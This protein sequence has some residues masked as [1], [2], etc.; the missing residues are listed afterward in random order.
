MICRRCLQ[1]ASSL[2][3]RIP[4]RVVPTTTPSFFLRPFSSTISRR[5]SSP[6]P[7]PSSPSSASESP[8][9]STPLADTPAA[10][11]KPTL[12]ACPEGTV[13]TGLNYFKNRTDP[14]ALADDAYPAWLWNCLNVQKKVADEADDDAGDEF[15]KSKKQRKLA[16]KRQRA[17]EARLL[18]EGNLEALAPKIPLQHQTINLPGNEEGTT[19]GA[20]AAAAARE[21]LRKAMR[22]ERRAKIKEDNYLRSM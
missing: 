7:E 18:A 9:F 13:L 15:S 19:Q 5:T 1:R 17:L 10:D 8:A 4:A 22:R 2:S 16:A 12:S 6:A 3:S 21:E 20:L 11:E 14:V